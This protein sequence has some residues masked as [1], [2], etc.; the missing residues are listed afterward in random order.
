VAA[1]AGIDDE[2][3]LA[4][5]FRELEEHN[6]GGKVVDVGESQRHEALGE[7]MRDG[8]QGLY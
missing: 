8:L 5:G 3:F 4:I 2:L 1:K 6:L 7:L